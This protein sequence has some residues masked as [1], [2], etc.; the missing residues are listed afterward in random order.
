[1]A[2]DSDTARIWIEQVQPGMQ[3]T[4]LLAVLSAR[5][6][7]LVRPYYGSTPNSQ[8]NGIVTGI[9]GG[10][11]YEVMVGRANLG[12]TYWDAFAVSL[13][14]AVCAILI[15]GIVSVAQRFLTRGHK[16]PQGEGQ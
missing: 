3:G 7:P 1:M 16:E 14:I 13:V 12:R 6:E 10:A 9:S 15:G 8:V 11:A 4:P 2:D 5:A